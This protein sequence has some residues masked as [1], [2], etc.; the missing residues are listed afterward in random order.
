[1]KKTILAISALAAAA[2]LSGCARGSVTEAGAGTIYSGKTKHFVA[3]TDNKIGS[4]EG[5]AGPLVNIIGIVPNGD[6]SIATAA[7]DGGIT[8]IATVDAQITNILG[9]YSETTL[10]V[11]GE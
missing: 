11:T 10:I 9:V 7:K 3:V 4:K 6:T 2:V 5:K 8:K 1:M